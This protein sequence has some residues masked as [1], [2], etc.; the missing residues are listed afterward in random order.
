MLSIRKINPMV[1]AVGTMGAVAAIVGGVTFA[2][3]TNTAALTTN[4]LTSGTPLLQVGT[5]S[6]AFADTAPGMTATLTPGITQSF[7]F[8]LQNNDT[9]PLSVT[10]SVPT[11]FTNS[12]IPASAVT[13]SLDCGA[14]AV[15]YP[16][17]SWA[18]GSA[19]IP[20]T[21]PAGSFSTCTESVTLDSTYSQSG[22]TLT[23]YTINFVGSDNS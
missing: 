8:Y 11:D 13:M 2:A 6:S 14:G 12:E 9:L 22:Q 23:P 1:R 15:I 16:L 10:A 7:T 3:Q 20:G 21:V 19:V 17:S 4:S 5:Q 18:G